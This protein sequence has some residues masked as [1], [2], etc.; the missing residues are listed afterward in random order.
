MIVDEETLKKI[1]TEFILKQET[2][3]REFIK[4]PIFPSQFIRTTE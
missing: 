4:E 1:D 2:K 3:R